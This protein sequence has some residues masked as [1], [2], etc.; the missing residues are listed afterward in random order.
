MA[1]PD[2]VV[3]N[4][5]FVFC[6]DI[7]PSPPVFQHHFYWFLSHAFFSPGFIRKVV[8][9][10]GFQAEGKTD[11]LD[12]HIINEMR[13]ISVFAIMIICLLAVS[14]CLPQPYSRAWNA[15]DLRWLGNLDAPTP[16]TT[17]LAVYTRTTA[18]TTEIRLDL[19]DIT[20]TD[21]YRILLA[22]W[23][24]R[25]YTS[26]PL[27]IEL[28][29][30]GA[31]HVSSAG[32]TS[33]WPRV[34][35]DY[36]LDTVTFSLNRFL[37]GRRFRIDVSTFTT[38]P[39][40]LAD[41]ARGILSDGQPPEGKAPVVLAFW[42]SFPAATAAQALRRWDGAHTGPLGGRHG[43]RTILEASGQFKIPVILLDLK[44]PSSLAALDYVQGLGRVRQLQER[45]LVILPDDAYAEPAKA[46]LN[47]SRSAG[48]G[49]SLPES[50]FVYSAG[51]TVQTSYDAQ[52]LSLPDMGHLAF[53]GGTK[54][55]PLPQANSDQAVEDGPTIETRRQL[56]MTA[57]SAD[58]ADL[59]VLGGSLPNSTWGNPERGGAAFAWLA[60]HPWIKSLNGDD[61]L[62]FPA[63]KTYTAAAL[64]PAEETLWLEELAAAPNN[65]A[66][67]AAWEMYLALNQPT[68][69]PQLQAVREVYLG[70]TDELLAAAAW[71]ENPTE[72]VDCSV[73]LNGG[74]KCILSNQTLFAIIDPA[75]ARLTTLFYKNGMDLHQVIGPSSQF[76][77][78]LSD[79]SE[80]R[81]DQGQAADPTVI[82]GAFSD[83][84]DPF[85]KY[86]I[87][88]RAPIETVQ[89]AASGTMSGG[90]IKLI[91]SDGT[92]NKTFRLLEDGIEVDYDFT[93][94]VT[95]RIPLALDA[96][97]FFEGP[98]FYRADLAPHTWKWSRENGGSVEVR[99]DAN[100]S[101]QGF[102]SSYP[103][104]SMPEDP[105]LD[106]PA[107]HY[108][109][110]PLS[111]VSISK[112]QSFL[113]QIIIK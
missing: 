59:V 27:T 81:P 22:F 88:I 84:I 41:E 46:S 19:L 18:L 12:R 62:A 99:S 13:R 47:F 107:G 3:L 4:E 52:F 71:A 8:F 58:P 38:E 2:H 98:S 25:D 33:I 30:T 50:R 20:P 35:Q 49:F 37:V 83:E 89:K 5:Q 109:P 6:L 80:W 23:D 94:V 113:V 87:S 26:T 93:Q 108:M 72:K 7:D 14:A 51:G 60:A 69:D 21:K 24:D 82:A 48:M 105:N 42:D 36:A 76:A 55:I 44:T 15:G 29:S 73:F 75:G 54:F 91:S 67:K 65:V 112:S 31:V 100:L 74:E 86:S 70:Y 1:N 10:R 79:P 78:G 92:R 39:P 32:K 40:A 28:S 102:L 43:L 101:A 11:S 104:L 97:A 110:F 53:S 34:I 56:F 17:I 111:I 103:F 63:E 85:Q 64:P 77:V 16:A 68:T 96:Q 106:Y 45:G 66:G 9:S 57:I 95:T 61:L 90:G